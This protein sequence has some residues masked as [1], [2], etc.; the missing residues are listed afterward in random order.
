LEGLVRFIFV[1]GEKEKNKK[2]EQDWFLCSV[3]DQNF[4]GFG[5]QQN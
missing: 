5:A 2:D 1:S 3:L 4:T